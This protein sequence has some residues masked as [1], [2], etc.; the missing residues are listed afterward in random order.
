MI[1]VYSKNRAGV[2]LL[3]LLTLSAP[4]GARAD[5]VEIEVEADAPAPSSPSPDAALRAQLD[6]LQARLAAIE[7]ARAAEAAAAAVPPPAPP[8]P[9][10]PK[11]PAELMGVE[12][13]GYLQAQAVFS[14]LSEDEVDPDGNPMNLDRFLIRRARLR[15]ERAFPY[16]RAVVELDANTVDGPA[17]TVKRVEASAIL[18][19]PKDGPSA[20]MLTAGLSGIPFGR[21]LPRSSRQRVFMERSLGSRALFP[22]EY[23]VGVTLAGALGPLNYA[24]AGQNGVP[25][26]SGNSVYTEEK[27][28][29]GRVGFEAGRADRVRVI[30]GFSYLTG[31]GFH[32]GTPATK[33]QLLWSD[34]NED[35]TV[36]LS[37]LEAVNGQAATPSA[38]FARWGV[39]ADLTAS[40]HSPLGQ[41]EL[42]VEATMASNLDRGWLP[43]DPLSTGYDLR[44]L[45]W[46]VG[47]T[48]EVTG[49][50]LVGF[51]ADRYDPNSD[52]FESRRGTFIPTDASVLTLS[53]VLGVQ[54]EDTA[55]LL[56]QYDYVVD[57]L[58]RDNLAQPI[59]LPNDQ[60]TVRVQ[61]AF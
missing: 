7:A 46:T 34:D 14:Q 53:P 49:W 26:S 24:V 13:S 4:L 40:L 36:T 55:R 47:F 15:A 21:E 29:V 58:G 33:S 28:F 52:L 41:S 10:A 22:S 25:V 20:A 19:N 59:D 27:T 8:P 61:G 6:A 12:L 31:T 11:P 17:V 44:E 38:T 18:P 43:A 45:A 5:D 50:G 57:F 23:D 16:G 1:P 60:W 9:P 51:R 30:A 35:G 42:G 32:A 54:F 2:C 56:V 3:G 48:Q 39:N 37:E